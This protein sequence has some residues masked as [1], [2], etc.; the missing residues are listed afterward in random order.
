MYV[1]LDLKALMLG[2]STVHWSSEFH[3][4]ITLFEKKVLIDILIAPGL[5]QFARVP[6]CAFTNNIKRTGSKEVKNFK[7]IV[8]AVIFVIR[9]CPYS[10]VSAF[11]SGRL[12]AG[13][14]EGA[15][16]PSQLENFCVSYIFSPK[17]PSPFFF[18]GPTNKPSFKYPTLNAYSIAQQIVM[19]V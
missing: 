8:S 4:L 5:N 6:S 2:A 16:P 13:S 12:G 18:I 9:L 15:V 14:G 7:F 10:I 17:R 11:R 1:N 19:V 3:L